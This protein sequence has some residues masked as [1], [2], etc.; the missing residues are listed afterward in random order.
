MI[1][2][3]FQFCKYIDEYDYIKRIKNNCTFHVGLENPMPREHDSLWLNELLDFIQFLS[4]IQ[5]PLRE[6]PVIS[7]GFTFLHEITEQNTGKLDITALREIE[8]KVYPLISN[9]FLGLLSWTIGNISLSAW[10]VFYT[11]L[12]AQTITNFGNQISIVIIS[13]YQLFT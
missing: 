1:P 5:P 6:W 11:V 12:Y 3:M 9:S 10:N 7:C 13:D 2:N 8:S 4:T